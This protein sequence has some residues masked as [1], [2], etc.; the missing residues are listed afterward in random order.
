MSRINCLMAVLAGLLLAAGS[1]AAQT[2]LW[3]ANE[4]SS[5]LAEFQSTLKGGSQSPN[6]L[7]KDSNDLAGASTIA[8]DQNENL[9]VT[10]FNA[11]TITEFPHSEWETD[12]VEK[13]SHPAASVT[14][15]EDAGGNLDGPE[16]IVF[17]SSENMW[18][19]AEDGKVILEYTPAQYVASGNPTPNVIL[20]ADSFKFSSPS[21]L[22]FDASGNLWV[23][24]EN[25]ANGQGG[26]GEIFRY[27]KD[28]ITA[29]T[30]GNQN[31]DPVFGI[32]LPEFVHLETIAFDGSGNLWEADQ[33]GNNLYQ[34]SASQ[35]TGTGLS[36][37]LTPAAVLSATHHKGDCDQTLD[38][39]YG[40]AVDGS[41][42][43]FVA[44]VRVHGGCRG[45]LA[46]FSAGSIESSG[47]PKPEVFITTDGKRNSIDAPNALTF[48]PGL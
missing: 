41:G 28:Q 33:Q 25:R 1:A 39:P 7:I 19:G 36:Q 37:N 4:N 16:G 26:N 34:F 3:V 42:D 46:E 22:A 47:S 30:S 27:D 44:N 21:H 20:N 9:W 24:D 23:V 17:D 14:I 35:L 32:A 5:T 11:N 18:V 45:S 15:S 43:L 13:H 29:L 31:I 10:N 12:A 48:G 38:G 2:G 40:L 6:G 8:F